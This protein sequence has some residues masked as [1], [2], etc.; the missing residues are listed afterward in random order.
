[1]ILFKNVDICDLDSILRHDILS[2]DECGN[3]NWEDGDRANNPTDRAMSEFC[4]IMFLFI[5]PRRSW[6]TRDSMRGKREERE[7]DYEKE[8]GD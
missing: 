7:C 8:L 4:L 2:M 5:M 6:C 1:M 3:D